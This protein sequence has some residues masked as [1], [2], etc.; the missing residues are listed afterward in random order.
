MAVYQNDVWSSLARKCHSAWCTIS[1]TT[2]FLQLQHSA[3]RSHTLTAFSWCKAL[4]RGKCSYVYI[5]VREK[6]IDQ[7]KCVNI[8]MG[9]GLLQIEVIQIE[10]KFE[11]SWPFY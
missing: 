9:L 5:K 1:P 4:A 7:Q 3:G 8:F 6:E 10:S 2:S 11:K